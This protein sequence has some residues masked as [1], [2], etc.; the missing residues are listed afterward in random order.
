MIF[1]AVIVS[2]SLSLSLSLSRSFLASKF[3]LHAGSGLASLLT[4]KLLNFAAEAMRIPLP[5]HSPHF[6]TKKNQL[7]LLSFPIFLACWQGPS[8]L[9]CKLLNFAA[10]A[11]RI[12]LPP[13]LPCKTSHE[14]LH[15]LTDYYALSFNLKPVPF[16]NVDQNAF[17]YF[18]GGN[19]DP[20]NRGKPIKIKG[21]RVMHGVP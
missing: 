8:L 19:E 16:K 7:I 18:Y 6:Q 9:K 11:M 10:G 21:K 1:S 4:C 2:V 15:Y 12:P 5:P 13:P 20:N 3:F 17:Y 14:M